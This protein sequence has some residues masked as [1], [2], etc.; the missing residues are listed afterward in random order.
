VALARQTMSEIATGVTSSLLSRASDVVLR[1]AAPG[2]SPLRETPL[3]PATAHHDPLAEMGAITSLLVPAFYNRPKRSTTHQSH[4]SAPLYLS[5][6][7]LGGQALSGGPGGVAG[8]L[9]AADR[10]RHHCP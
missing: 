4:W 7:R 8:D 2:V 6:S 1:S 10:A 9:R 5:P 3:T